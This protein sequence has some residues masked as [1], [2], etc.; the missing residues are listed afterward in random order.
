[1]PNNPLIVPTQLANGSLHFAEV[2]QDGTAQD[3]INALDALD[4]V[5]KDES[6]YEGGHGWALQRIRIEQ[7]GRPWEEDE[8]EALGDGERLHCR[9]NFYLTL[10]EGIIP[11]STRV[12]PLVNSMNNPASSQ[13]HFSSF[14]MTSH[15]HTPILRLVSLHPRLSLSFDFAR[16]PEIHDGFNWKIF[17]SKSTTASDIVGTTVNELGLTKALHIQGG[18]N[19]EYVLEEV[20]CD[21]KAESKTT[22]NNHAA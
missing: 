18:G 1:M 5:K 21:G 11:P 2:G 15:L 3:V 8:L 20:W 9:A 16:V 14:P 6:I 22:V 19:L 10:Y 13:T 12:A 17:I 7:N 4:E